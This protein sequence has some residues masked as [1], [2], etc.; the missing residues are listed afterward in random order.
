VPSG[1]AAFAPRFCVRIYRSSSVFWGVVSPQHMKQIFLV[2]GTV[3]AFAPGFPS[4]H[5]SGL[6]REAVYTSCLPLYKG[7]KS[8]RSDAV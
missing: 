4:N 2:G 1:P 8:K 5:S 6:L 3:A 7:R